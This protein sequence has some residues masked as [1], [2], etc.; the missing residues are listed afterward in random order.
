[1]RFQAANPEDGGSLGPINSQ[2]WG[3]LC[4]PPGSDFRSEQRHPP[5]QIA[6]RTVNPVQQLAAIDVG[7]DHMAGIV[8]PRTTADRKPPQSEP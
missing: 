1:M 6:M 8:A 7:M 3:T 4:A 2:S 5:D